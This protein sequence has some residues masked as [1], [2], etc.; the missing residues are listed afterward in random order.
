MSW[1]F[2]ERECLEQ[3]YDLLIATSMVD[4]ATLRGLVPSLAAI[5]SLYYFHENQ[6]DYPQHSQRHSLL[7]AQ[8]VSLYGALAADRLV[9]NSRYNLQ[10]FVQ[11]CD[12]LLSR[13][14]DEVPP[15]IPAALRDKS[16][17]LAVPLLPA[18][19]AADS[20]VW[21]GGVAGLPQ[22]TLRIL[23][24][25]RFEHDKGGEGLQAILRLLERQGM[26]YELAVTGQQFRNSPQVF[27]EIEREFHHR[28][29]QFG[30]VESPGEYR[31]L[32]Q[33]ADVVLSTALHEFQGLA[34]M[35]AVQAGCLPV[36]PDRLAYS[37][38]YSPVYRYASN[39]DDLAA[40]AS[41]AL[42]LL[43][44]LAH[45]LSVGEA[46]IP[47]MECFTTQALRPGYRALL[48]GMSGVAG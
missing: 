2:S 43:L 19:E 11:G 44:R 15:G 25:A 47:S 8:M 22:H 34:V 26:D 24:S 18:D 21:S 40:E 33:G 14:P 30:Y 36:V 10:T 4:L 9:F 5:P 45:Q 41:S 37:E 28:L 38:L 23:W 27:A 3:P 6:F 17:V 12:E 29:V 13:L 35:Q 1:A 16:S 31:A 42:A 48:Q 46:Q 32:Q 39:T 20:C 7:E